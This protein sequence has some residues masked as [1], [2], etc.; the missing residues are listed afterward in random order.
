MVKF[1][2]KQLL[3]KPVFRFL[4]IFAF[5]KPKHVLLV[6]IWCMEECRIFSNYV[7]NI[8]FLHE[9]DY[10]FL[11]LAVVKFSVKQL[12]KKPVFRFLPIFAFGKPKH[13]LLVKI[14]CMEECRIFSNYWIGFRM[15]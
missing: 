10:R 9:I 4:P 13:V 12:L 2:V 5:G 8:I 11:P 1:S 3:K 14:W 7:Y 6:K 15:I